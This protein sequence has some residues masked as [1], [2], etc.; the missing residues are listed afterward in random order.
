M[1]AMRTLSIDI[2][3]TGIK[4]TVL[5]AAGAPLTERM[6]VNTPRAA[7]PEAVLGVIAELAHALGEFD[8]VSI[9]FPGVVHDGMTKTAPNLDDAW[10]GFA[11]QRRVEEDTLGKPTR[12]ANDATIQGLDVI[13]RRGLEAIITLGTG[14]GCC[15]FVDGRPWELEL[16]HHPFR[17][18]KPYEALLG[19]E[20]RKDIGNTRWNKRVKRALVQLEALFNYDR[21]YIGGGNAKHLDREGLS[22]NVTVVDNAAGVLGGI[23]LWD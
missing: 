3:G 4:A 1:M 9:G 14:L 22:E 8:R 2:G 7:T 17:K 13:Q 18:G 10:G 11:L 5:D 19:N 6:R 12:V 16:G 23:R 21:L 20:A 15:L